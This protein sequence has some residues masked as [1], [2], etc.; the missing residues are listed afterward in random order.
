MITSSFS[1]HIIL[2]LLKK[3]K[4][5]PMMPGTY[6]GM[7]GR[8]EISNTFFIHSGRTTKV[9]RGL[10]FVNDNRFV[11]EIHISFSIKKIKKENPENRNKSILVRPSI[12]ILSV[13]GHQTKS[14]CNALPDLSHKSGQ[15]FIL[16][17]SYI[18]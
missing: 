14:L 7:K 1:I 18:I 10:F 8:R 6:G 15:S 11:G 13:E 5:F 17:P 16:F 3:S 9:P 4:I 2:R 12:A